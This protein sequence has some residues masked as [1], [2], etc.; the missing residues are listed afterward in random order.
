MATELVT[1]VT[2]I[3]K[4]IRKY[5]QTPLKVPKVSMTALQL[6]AHNVFYE[7]AVCRLDT[8]SLVAHPLGAPQVRAFENPPGFAG[9]FLSPISTSITRLSW[10]LN[11]SK[12]ALSLRYRL[13][14]GHHLDDVHLQLIIETSII[15]FVPIECFMKEQSVA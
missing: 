5:Q 6:C 4:V 14:N 10:Q 7:G 9:W 11:C 13:T 2:G 15:R 1:M 8:F 3:L 12:R